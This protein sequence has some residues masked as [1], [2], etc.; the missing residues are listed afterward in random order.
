MGDVSVGSR[1]KT[2]VELL[3]HRLLF[4]LMTNSGMWMACHSSI[5]IFCRAKAISL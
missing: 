1:K 4:K 2:L 3:G 5:W